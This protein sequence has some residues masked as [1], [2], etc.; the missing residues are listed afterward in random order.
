MRARLPRK[1]KVDSF[2][3]AL[4]VAGSEAKYGLRMI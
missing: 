2:E 3:K 4:R 1:K